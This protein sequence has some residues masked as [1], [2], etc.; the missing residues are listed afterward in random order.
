MERQPAVRGNV[1]RRAMRGQAAIEY[2]TTYGWAILALVIVTAVLISSGIFSPTYLVAEECNFGNTLK[3]DAAVFNQAGA[4]T[5][6]VNFFNGFPYKV[7][8][9]DFTLQTQDGM[10][11]TGLPSNI[12][13]E[14]GAKH[15]FEGSLAEPLPNGA[16]KRFVGNITYVSC[17]PEIGPVCST[18]THSISGRMTARVVE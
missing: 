11:V 15:L 2:L 5:V 13:L 17:A 8:I 4:T 14:S 9:V 10:V 7:K 16:I 18:V 12:E 3:C 6:D 1:P